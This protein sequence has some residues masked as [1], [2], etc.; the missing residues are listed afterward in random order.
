MKELAMSIKLKVTDEDKKQMA[1]FAVEERVLIALANERRFLL[2]SKAQDILTT[3]GMSPK[4]YAMNFSAPEDKWEA[5]L[6]PGAIAVP[7]PGTDLSKIKG[8]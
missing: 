3:N 6:R 1:K 8:N 7:V 4:L 5:V 2:N